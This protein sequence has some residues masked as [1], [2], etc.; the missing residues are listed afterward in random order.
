MVWQLQTAKQKFSELVERAVSDGP[1]VVTKHGREVVVVVSIDEYRR[2]SE[3]RPSFKKFLLEA[4]P[5]FDALAPYLER[6][7]DYGRDIEL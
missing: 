4:P 2:L 3:K 7:D 6:E 1:Q 5:E